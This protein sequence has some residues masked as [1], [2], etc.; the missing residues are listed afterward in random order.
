MALCLVLG[1]I[2]C[3]FCIWKGVK[4]TGRVS[5][6]IIIKVIQ[7][8]NNHLQEH[9]HPALWPH[10]EQP[11]EK[12]AFMFWGSSTPGIVESL[13]NTGIYTQYW[14]FLCQGSV[15]C[16]GHQVWA[17]P[18]YISHTECL[19]VLWDAGYWSMLSFEQRYWLLWPKDRVLVISY[20]IFVWKCSEPAWP[21]AQL[22][23]H[24]RQLLH[25]IGDN[26]MICL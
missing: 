26:L 4:T 2:I 7:Y 19:H 12:W 11:D 16:N 6:L 14:N 22:K 9:F 25:V 23:T 24:T 3:Y 20:W 18:C 8:Y 21:C 10:H 1:W 5:N 13:Q 15:F 17:W